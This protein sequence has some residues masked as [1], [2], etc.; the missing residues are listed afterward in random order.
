MAH[1]LVGASA[2][3]N[4]AADPAPAPSSQPVPPGRLLAHIACL[5][6]AC[7][8]N[9][10]SADLRARLGMAYA[11]NHDL[12]KSMDTLSAATALDP[13]HFWAQLKYA[14]LNYRLR[15]LPR[16]EHETLKAVR[17]ARHPRELSAAQEQLREIRNCLSH[18]ARPLTIPALICL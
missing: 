9:P 3:Q 14:E 7:L 18:V 17:L 2:P 1:A 10:R 13:T 15:A 6:K 12:Y 4:L 5:E 16:A 8:D 11:V